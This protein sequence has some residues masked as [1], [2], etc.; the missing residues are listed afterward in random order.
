VVVSAQ[1][2]GADLEFKQIKLLTIVATLALTCS[3]AGAQA[4]IVFDDGHGKDWRQ[5]TDTAGIG[6]SDIASA[7]P[8]N[9]AT[10]CSG[11]VDGVNMTGWVFA[12]V[13]QVGQLFSY[14][15]EFP[16]GI[17][18]VNVPSTSHASDF[19]DNAINQTYSD[20][21]YRAVF[22]WTSTPTPGG[23]IWV[24]EVIDRPPSDPNGDFWSTDDNFGPGQSNFVGA[25]MWQPSAVPEPATW[26]MFII[27]F[28]AMG[29]LLRA[30][31]RSSEAGA[32]P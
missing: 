3:S 14:F 12:S 18:Q 15:G 23:S 10:A 26:A 11:T 17:D 24:A 7:C 13:D 21:I 25:W 1:K 8:L 27:G 9:G 6:W 2:E 5:V 31:R 4:A 29:A 19:L 16:G 32:I 28:G 30:N 20:N 22:G